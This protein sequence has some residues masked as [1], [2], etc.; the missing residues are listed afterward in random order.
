MMIKARLLIGAQSVRPIGWNRRSFS[1]N[2]LT[3]ERTLW[4]LAVN[5]SIYSCEKPIALLIS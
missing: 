5:L 1:L 2:L 4:I 3:Y